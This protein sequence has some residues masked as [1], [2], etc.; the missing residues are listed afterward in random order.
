MSAIKPILHTIS[1]KG[2]GTGHSYYADFAAGCPLQ[3]ALKY[4][5]GRHFMTE[6]SG[7]AIGTIAHALWEMHFKQQLSPETPPAA[8]EFSNQIDEENRV[9]AERLFKFVRSVFPELDIFGK[10]VENEATHS[11]A[12]FGPTVTFKPDLITDISKS[13]LERL[14]RRNV[15]WTGHLGV[16]KPG[17]VMWDFKHLGR[18]EN[19][20]LEKALGSTQYA[21]Y[22]AAYNKTNKVKIAYT[23]Q[24][25]VF[26]LKEIVIRMTV[27]PPPT[28]TLE[29]ATSLLLNQGAMMATQSPRM[30]IPHEDNCFPYGSTCRYLKEGLCDRTGPTEEGLVQLKAGGFR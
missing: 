13:Q 28:A 29:K 23:V 10:I 20:H 7:A 17:R 6:K 5:D 30:V 26:K 24:I 9:E 2:S 11:T 15:E 18:R 25:T 19:N 16:R 4:S 12:V 14:L 21:S 27:I 3:A 1:G 22:V 8:V